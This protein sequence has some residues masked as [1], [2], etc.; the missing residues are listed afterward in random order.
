[1][2]K[3]NLYQKVAAM[4][5]EFAEVKM[6][7]SGKNSYSN[8]DYFELSD[9]LPKAIGLCDKYG[10]LPVISFN[11]GYAVMTVYDADEPTSVI[12]IT[13]PMAEANLKGCHPI[14]NMGAVE[15]YSRRYLWMAFLE[16]VENDPVDASDTSGKEN[17]QP[18]AVK[19]STAPSD[20]PEKDPRPASQFNARA[21]WN[22]VCLFFGYDQSKGADDPDNRDALAEAHKLFDPYAKSI[23]DLTE[24]KGKAILDR[25]D[26]MR[27][28]MGPESFKGDDL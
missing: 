12:T 14:Q 6:E 18:K 9:F 10:V 23:S 2:E 13:S 25:L 22:E 27:S 8:Y 21:V 3:R 19:R 16:I 11:Q 7:K 28:G 24:E 17:A 1:M 4:R 5:K 15:T 20:A 26:V